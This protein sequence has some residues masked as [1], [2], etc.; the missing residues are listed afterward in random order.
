[1]K[2]KSVA[3]LAYE[4]LSKYKKPLHYRKITE[5]LLKIKP[6]KVKEPC[7][8]V[9][10]SMSGDKRFMRA[11]RGIWGLVKW[12]Y[13]DANIKYSLTSYC[14]KDGAVF[15]TSYMKPYFPK[16]EKG[17]EVIFLDKNGEEIEARVNYQLNRI[18]GLKKWYEK[19]RLKVNDVIYIGLIDYDRRKY[20]LV[21][22]NETV[23]EFSENLKERMVEILEEEG[24]PLPYKEIN[25]RLLEFNATNH[26]LF[27]SSIKD[28]LEKDKKFVQKKEDYWGLFDWLNE[29]EQLEYEL[30]HSENDEQF[31]NAI[32]KAFSYLGFESSIISEG[33]SSF[34][35][36][37]AWL[38]YE[39]Y[40]LI[41]EGWNNKGS[42]DQKYTD[43]AYW[44]DWGK[45]KEKYDANSLTIIAPHFNYSRLVEWVKKYNFILCELKWLNIL[46]KEH[47]KIPFS[48]ISLKTFFQSSNNIESNLKKLIQQRE[49]YYQK[50][51][52]IN[53]M[54]KILI[55]NNQKKSF[56]TPES[57]TRIINQKRI[58]NSE[59]Q[60]IAI[61]E[62]KEIC[63]LLSQEPINILKISE[64]DNIILSFNLELARKRLEKII[65]GIF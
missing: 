28:I 42:N 64:E 55:E 56:L 36:A 16:D 45:V 52:L 48:L 58:K 18:I 46:L 13:K 24:Q 21:T 10:A 49:V 41:I 33:K 5:E 1:M 9:N 6:L 17:I 59:Y 60:E 26:N 8:T 62:I 47:Q 57:L 19:K 20:F 38:D 15:L 14:L 65:D 40:H 43:F 37:N 54:I 3:D 61:S 29:F 23:G 12:K 53:L 4:I 2:N 51:N 50:I 11:K 27:Q 7:Y 44:E 34:I 35:L 22:E 30:F 39:S 32:L 63:K 25:K 31:K